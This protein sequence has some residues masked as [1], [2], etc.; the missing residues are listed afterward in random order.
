MIEQIGMTFEHDFCYIILLF[1]SLFCR[2]EEKSLGQ[3]A[4]LSARSLPM[5]LNWINI[6]YFLALLLFH[7]VLYAITLSSTYYTLYK[8]IYM[9]IQCSFINMY[10]NQYVSVIDLNTITLLNAM[11]RINHFF[12]SLGQN[13]IFKYTDKGRFRF[14]LKRP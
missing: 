7:V 11:I 14:S 13:W 1:S 4:Y 9:Y 2:R 6:S 10:P 12:K 8:N 5:L 3:K